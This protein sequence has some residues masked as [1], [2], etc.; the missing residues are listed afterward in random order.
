MHSTLTKNLGLDPRKDTPALE[1]NP[2]QGTAPAALLQENELLKATLRTIYERRPSDFRL[3]AQEMRRADMEAIESTLPILYRPERAGAPPDEVEAL[4]L[5]RYAPLA[6]TD[7]A[8]QDV[9]EQHPS[10][11]FVRYDNAMTLV[12][13]LKRDLVSEAS[14]FAML[15]RISNWLLDFDCEIN[16]FTEETHG[17]LAAA[18][19][20]IA[21]I[22]SLFARLRGAAQSVVQEALQ[23]VDDMPYALDRSSEDAK[24][25]NCTP[26]IQ[27][28]RAAV[29]AS[30]ALNWTTPTIKQSLIVADHNPSDSEQANRA[31]P[32]KGELQVPEYITRYIEAIN[33]DLEKRGLDLDQRREVVATLLTT[34]I[35]FYPARYAQAPVPA[36][37]SYRGALLWALYHHQGGNSPVGQPIRTLLGI[38][39]FAAM[40]SEQIEE[41]VRFSNEPLGDGVGAAHTQQHESLMPKESN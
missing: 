34:Y 10:G 28:L 14:N 26:S 16:P 8:G 24:A 6:L 31:A 21:S 30:P 2:L 40:T 4:E 9:M 12:S 41:A 37:A 36:Q 22:E 1:E 18:D 25:K 3:D 35:D 38:D 27:A 5:A 11:G 39:R 17:P 32:A 29:K 19:N 15:M 23:T 7:P 33:A 20:V 13:E